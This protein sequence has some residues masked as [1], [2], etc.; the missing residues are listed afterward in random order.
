MKLFGPNSETALIAEDDD[1][2]VDTNALIRRI[3]LPVNTVFKSAI[4]IAPVARAT[5]QSKS[6]GSK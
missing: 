4:T 2:G 1:S 5:I 3:S 6:S